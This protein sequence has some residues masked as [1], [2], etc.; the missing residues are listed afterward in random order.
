MKLIKQRFLQ[1]WPQEWLIA[2]LSGVL[3]GSGLVVAGMT[4]PEKVLGFLEI[5]G[6]WDPTLMLVMGGAIMIN[7]PA[8]RLILKR[9]KPVIGEHFYL[10]VSTAIDKP[11]I[12]G[13]ALFGIGWGIAG[14][15]PGPAVASLLVGGGD[16]LLFATAMLGGFWLQKISTPLFNR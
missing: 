2:L 3:M 7:L 11:L 14:I 4:N 15:C 16:M 5:T 1:R 12:I 10:P 6:Q 13:A 9:Q 8:S